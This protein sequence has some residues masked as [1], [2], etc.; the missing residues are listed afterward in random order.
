MNETLFRFGIQ[1][2]PIEHQV[3]L[4]KCRNLDHEVNS[5]QEKF[6]FP[7]DPFRC[8]MLSS[9]CPNHQDSEKSLNTIP[10]ADISFFMWLF[11]DKFTCGAYAGRKRAPHPP[12]CN[13]QRG[14]TD[15]VGWKQRR[16]VDQPRTAS[17]WRSRPCRG[18]TDGRPASS[19]QR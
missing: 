8:V 2:L 13:H 4:C 12:E 10:G 11:F 18:K 1:A 19:Q 17:R 6:S 15:R 14:Q 7:K 3:T 9:S 5:A 16:R